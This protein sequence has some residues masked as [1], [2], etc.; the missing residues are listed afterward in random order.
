MN[1]AK[2][3]IYNAMYQLLL[4]II[5]LI[6]APYVA[7]VLGAEK[8]GIYSYSYSIANYFVLIAQLGLIALG[9]RSI[10]ACKDNREELNRTFCSIYYVQLIVAF[11]LC[12]AYILYLFQFCDENRIIFIIQF[13]YVA[14]SL[15]DINWLFF[16]L[17]KFKLT[18]TRNTIIKCLT[19]ILTLYFVNES[20]DLWKY[21][22]ILASG[23]LVSQLLL[24]PYLHKFVTFVKVDRKLIL[25]YVKPALI[26]FIPT[27][28]TSVYRIMSKIMIGNFSNMIQVG[29]YENSEKFSSISLGVV[30][31]L[32]IV[33][34][35]RMSNIIS[36]G[37]EKKARKYIFNSMT[38]IA[39]IASALT[40]GLIGVAPVLAPVF[41]GSEFSDCSNIISIISVSILCISWANVIRTQYLVP[42]KKDK[43]YIISVFIG[44]IINV[45]LNC[46]L[47]PQYGAIGAA[48]GT[49]I[50][51]FLVAI[52]QT[53]FLRK[54]LP[55]FSYVKSW[56]PQLIIGFI[57]CLVVRFIG[58]IMGESIISLIIQIAVGGIIYI[59]TTVV[60]LYITKSE[61][62]SYIKSIKLR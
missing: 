43:E 57:M 62:L 61:L 37:E 20:S 40:F 30:N 5:P 14:S 27:I 18:V 38:I 60:Y 11:F 7:R 50:A 42:R 47:I 19:V 13:L 56:T 3:F 29:Y 58:N 17:E 39:I 55:I 2:N 51:E 15:F 33:M 16:G 45:I 53:I 32:G 25:Y 34:L 4:I 59:I 24:W 26:L 10:A 28:A 8:L 41:Y 6:T 12:G 46:M 49:L 9:N 1:L 22:L 44:A 36:R 48:I 23:T 35:P 21:T 54:E 52:T 31:A